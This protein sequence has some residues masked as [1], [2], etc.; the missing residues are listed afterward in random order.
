MEERRAVGIVDDFAVQLDRDASRVG[1]AFGPPAV[2]GRN[3]ADRAYQTRCP[4]NDG[5]EMADRPLLLACLERTADDALCSIQRNQAPD[6]AR[7]LEPL[8][9]AS[10]AF[11]PVCSASRRSTPTEVGKRAARP[12]SALPILSKASRK[13]WLSVRNDECMSDRSLA[14]GDEKI[15]DELARAPVK[16]PFGASMRFEA[17]VLLVRAKAL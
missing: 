9:L 6:D 11:P 8:P 3:F 1:L 10:N 16:N 5:D 12:S 15:R 17:F 4:V 7:R 2:I 13:N 14:Q